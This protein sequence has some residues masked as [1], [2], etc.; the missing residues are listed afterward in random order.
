[1]DELDEY[2]YDEFNYSG[3]EWK[4]DYCGEHPEE[5]KCSKCGSTEM[6]VAVGS[7]ATWVRCSTCKG[8][9]MIHEG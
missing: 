2:I 8:E 3:E 7:Y 9:Q 4:E 5:L 1:M 6:N